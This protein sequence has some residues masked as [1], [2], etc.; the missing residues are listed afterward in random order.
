MVVSAIQIKFNESR[1]D[2]PL[3]VIEVL[4]I[5][6]LLYITFESCELSYSILSTVYS[7]QKNRQT[8]EI[9]FDFS[10]VE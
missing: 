10:Y 9:Y 1:K 5:L 2:N 6:Q 7:R 3:T 4:E 8:T